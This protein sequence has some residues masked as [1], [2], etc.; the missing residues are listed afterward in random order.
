M[1]NRFMGHLKLTTVQIFS[2]LLHVSFCKK[3]NTPQIRL[4][5]L[6]FLTPNVIPFLDT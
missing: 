2:Y 5:A 3:N 1:Y 6:Y 4:R